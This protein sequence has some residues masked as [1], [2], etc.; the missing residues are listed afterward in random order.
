[1]QSF[2]VTDASD[3]SPTFEYTARGDRI[4]GAAYRSPSLYAFSARRIT[5]QT[6][7]HAKY[8]HLVGRKLS[9]TQQKQPNPKYLPF[10]LINQL[11]KHTLR[12]SRLLLRTAVKMRAPYPSKGSFSRTLYLIVFYVLVALAAKGTAAPAPTPVMFNAQLVAAEATT[13]YV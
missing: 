9:S 6:T 10:L 13:G 12:P 4:K 3:S 1:M 11:H 5:N 8:L 2:K 7:V